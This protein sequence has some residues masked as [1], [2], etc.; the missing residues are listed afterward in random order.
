MKKSVYTTPLALL[1]APL[2]RDEMEARLHS[3]LGRFLIAFA[4][5][6]LNLTLRVGNDKLFG[7]KLGRLRSSVL[8][9]GANEEASVKSSRGLKLP[10]RC[11]KYE[12]FLHM[13]A[14]D[15]SC[16]CSRQHLCQAIRLSIS[17]SAVFHWMSSTQ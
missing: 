2:Y 13:D 10:I 14:G 16:I 4:R 1:N 15:I 3:I 8:E 7:A 5:I 9:F 12:T 17:P 11:A 6:E